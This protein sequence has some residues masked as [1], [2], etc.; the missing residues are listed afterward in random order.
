MSLLA[1]TVMIT[2][3][4]CETYDFIHSN[5]TSTIKIDPNADQLIRVNFNIT[6]HDIQCDFVEVGKFLLLDKLIVM[7]VREICSVS[8]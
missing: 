3:F 1:L 8:L 2:L 6:L 5:V 4:I 7:S